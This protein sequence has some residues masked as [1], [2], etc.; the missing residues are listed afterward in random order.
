MVRRRRTRAAQY[1]GPS[2]VYWR[3]LRRGKSSHIAARLTEET[4]SANASWNLS[5]ILFS[6]V[7]VMAPSGRRSHLLVVF[8]VSLRVFGPQIYFV[9]W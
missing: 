9:L 7:S 1:H 3:V 2:S 4:G 8:I 6:G 5:A